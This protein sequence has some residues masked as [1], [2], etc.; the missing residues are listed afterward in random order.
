MTQPIFKHIATALTLASLLLCSL[1]G[2][3]K[4]VVIPKGTVKI[5][6]EMRYA[7]DETITSVVIA[8]TVKYIESM[9]FSNCTNLT[10]ITL[11]NSLERIGDHAFAA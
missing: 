9:A 1:N 6:Y 5:T 10:S 7:G 8:S 2:M 4:E 11:P 3:A